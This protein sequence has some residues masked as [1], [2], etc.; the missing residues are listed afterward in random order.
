LELIDERSPL[1]M[2]ARLLEHSTIKAK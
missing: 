1:S 2:L